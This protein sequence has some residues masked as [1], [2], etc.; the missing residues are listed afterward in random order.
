[1]PYKDHAM[2]LAK[3]K[4]WRERKMKEGYG[5]WL[6]E[7]RKLRFDDAERFRTAIE[8]AIDELH[9]VQLVLGFDETSEETTRKAAGH[10][11]AALEALTT[12]LH[13]SI[14]AEKTLGPYQHTKEKR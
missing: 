14:K 11:D 5:K 8:S 1:M 4:E 13:E 3:T 12:A 9:K 6:Y 2:K 10:T 7:R